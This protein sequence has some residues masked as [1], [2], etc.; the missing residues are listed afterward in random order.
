MGALGCSVRAKS[1]Y[2]LNDR[3]L[4]LPTFNAATIF[5]SCYN[6]SDR[7]DQITNTKSW[8]KRM[9]LNFQYTPKES[10]KC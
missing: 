5:S 9:L 2:A 6:L 3:F 7:S 8:P 4:D 10:N 1:C